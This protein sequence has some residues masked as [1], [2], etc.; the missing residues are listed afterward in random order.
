[1][2]GIQGDDCTQRPFHTL[3]STVS[4]AFLLVLLAVQQALR[5]V[6]GK[7]LS[8]E[9]VCVCVCVCTE[10][11]DG[12]PSTPWSKR[13]PLDEQSCTVSVLQVSLGVSWPLFIIGV[14]CTGEA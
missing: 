8:G 11:A 3:L 12:Y 9:C 10:S 4:G 5:R 14:L 13:P 1:M 6:L 7:L 2:L